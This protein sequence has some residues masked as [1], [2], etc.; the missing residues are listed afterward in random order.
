MITL[1]R[2]DKRVIVVNAELIKMI[3]STPDT[4]VTLINGDML[5][6][7]EAVDE[8][9]RRAIDYARQIRSFQVV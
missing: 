8:V 9:V 5:I 6:V 4:I 1:T 2:L 3:E 7:R